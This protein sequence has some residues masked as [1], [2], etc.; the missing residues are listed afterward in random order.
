M[1]VGAIGHD[2]LQ[3]I[4]LHIHRQAVIQ[5]GL[6]NSQGQRQEWL[7]N[8]RT[9]AALQSIFT[10]SRERTFRLLASTIAGTYYSE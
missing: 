4:R 10:S 2:L 3:H 1:R 8:P 9:S 7:T 5:H 6:K